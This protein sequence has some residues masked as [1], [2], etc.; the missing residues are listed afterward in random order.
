M[1][2]GGCLQEGISGVVIFWLTPEGCLGVQ[3]ASTGRTFRAGEWIMQTVSH[4]HLC[5]QTFEKVDAPEVP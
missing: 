2:G 1:S 3:P 5:L 4:D